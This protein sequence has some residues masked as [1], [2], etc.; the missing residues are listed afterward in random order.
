MK[1][2]RWYKAKDIRVEQI[3]EPQVTAGRVKIEVAW[4]GICGSDL[5][6]YVAGPIFIPVDAPHPVS[7]DIAP[8]VMGHEFSGKVVE[9][10]EGVTSVQVGDQV[11]VEPIL[12]CGEC[13][14]CKKG[15]YNIYRKGN[16]Q[17]FYYRVFI[18]IPINIRKI[19]LLFRCQFICSILSAGLFNLF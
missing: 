17:Y 4:T 5:H 2:A 8:I 19:S 14:A 15:K 11:V 3:D 13:G 16:K 6:E 10:G 12:A 18:F 9:I 7:K 1:A